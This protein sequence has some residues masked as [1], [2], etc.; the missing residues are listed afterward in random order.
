VTVSTP[1]DTPG[2]SGVVHHVRGLLLILRWLAEQGVLLATCQSEC[3]GTYR[4]NAFTTVED[5]EY[6]QL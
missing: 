2:Q 4:L 3:G 6:Q 5:D 1:T